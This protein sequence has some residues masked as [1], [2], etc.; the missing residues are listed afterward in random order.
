MN[1]LLALSFILHFFI[2]LRQTILT[3]GP[4]AC[5]L[6]RLYSRADVNLLIIL[7]NSKEN[8]RENLHLHF[9]NLSAL[10]SLEERGN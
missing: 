8:V 5:G 6:L 1:L 7:G 2:G 10:P 4:L 9:V 3:I